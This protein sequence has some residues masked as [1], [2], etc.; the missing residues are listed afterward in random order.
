LELTIKIEKKE[1]LKEIKDEKA[2]PNN[3]K[4]SV[5]GKFRY[6]MRAIK[7]KLHHHYTVLFYTNKFSFLRERK[8]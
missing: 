6:M 3:S 1:K 7:R 2:I 8:L 5:K 4:V